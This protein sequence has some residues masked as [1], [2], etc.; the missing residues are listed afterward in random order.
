M[1]NVIQL[2]PAEWV[3][4]SILMAV[5]GLKKNTIKHARNT[6]WME[7]REYRHVSGN[8]EPHETAPCFYKLKLIEEWIGRM[9]KA[10]RREKKS[11]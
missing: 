5:T 7:G 6:S 3:S 10:V 2:V 9:P 8:G 4:E 11:A 1:T